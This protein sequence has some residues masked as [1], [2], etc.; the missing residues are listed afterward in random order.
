MLCQMTNTVNEAL[1][2]LK[3]QK[4]GASANLAESYSI[5]EDPTKY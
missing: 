5:H 3:Q 4:C 1:R 2:Y